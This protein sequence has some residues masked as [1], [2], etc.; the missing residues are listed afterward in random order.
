MLSFFFLL[1]QSKKVQLKFLHL[2]HAINPIIVLG[3][4]KVSEALSNDIFR[5]THAK[6]HK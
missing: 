2:L 4:K 6:L 1:W 5:R 3:I